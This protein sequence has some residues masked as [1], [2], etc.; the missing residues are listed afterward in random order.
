MKKL[1]KM[2][3]IIPQK[4]INNKYQTKEYKILLNNLILNILNK[5]VYN[6]VKMTVEI[7][8]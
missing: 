8:Q 6:G 1:Q 2:M 3:L 7:I 5:K 4:P